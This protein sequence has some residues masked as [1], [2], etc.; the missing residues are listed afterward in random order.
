M[1]DNSVS[2]TIE[3]GDGYEPSDRLKA[4]VRELDQALAEAHADEVQ[5]FEYEEI[6]FTYQ[7]IEWTWA[8]GS[9]ISR[10]FG[11][12]VSPRDSASGLATG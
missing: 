4:A 1:S 10:K 6:Q 11:T 8:V 5:G 9:P 12:V 3:M 2:V 7:K